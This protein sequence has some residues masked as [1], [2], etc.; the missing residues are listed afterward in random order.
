MWSLKLPRNLTCSASGF[1]ASSSLMG[2][3]CR[4]LSL[5]A[6]RVGLSLSPALA[7]GRLPVG[8][9]PRATREL[10]AM[11]G[12]CFEEEPGVCE[13]AREDDDVEGLVFAGGVMEERSMAGEGG[14][15]GSLNGLVMSPRRSNAQVKEAARD[16]RSSPGQVRRGRQTP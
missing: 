5:L 2:A 15:E 3:F 8:V 12:G 13:G 11:A 14:G 16:Q 6:G 1:D 7:E 10:E 9:V 4:K